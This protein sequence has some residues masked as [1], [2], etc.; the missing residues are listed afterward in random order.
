MKICKY[1]LL[2]INKLTCFDRYQY[3]D[4]RKV[5]IALF[6]GVIYAYRVIIRN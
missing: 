2:F 1:D 6:S 3:D 4:S 5:N